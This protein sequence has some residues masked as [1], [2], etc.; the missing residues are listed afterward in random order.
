[1]FNK[2]RGIKWAVL[3]V[4][5]EYIFNIQYFQDGVAGM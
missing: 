3:D 1:M 5:I 4:C 2:E